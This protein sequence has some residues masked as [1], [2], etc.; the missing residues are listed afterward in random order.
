MEFALSE[1]TSLNFLINQAVA[2]KI[3]RMHA[4]SGTSKIDQPIEG[5]VP[6]DKED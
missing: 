3:T 4:Q 5:A 1:G 2:E 6:R